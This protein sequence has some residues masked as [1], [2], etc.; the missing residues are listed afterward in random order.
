MRFIKLLGFFVVLV[1]LEVTLVPF[2]F[3]FVALFLWVQFCEESE[4]FLLAFIVGLLFDLLLLR[5]LGESSLLFLLLLWLT[6]LYKRKFQHQ[7]IIFLSLLAFLCLSAIELFYK[8]S[9][10]FVRAFLGAV[11]TLILAR[12]HFKTEEKYESWYRLS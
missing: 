10:P 9:F 8:G 11:F 6:T 2:P 3:S 1:F 4:A 12:M 7:N 5:P